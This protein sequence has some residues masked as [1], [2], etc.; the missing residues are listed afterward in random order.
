[1]T[2]S[3]NQ[4]A[5]RFSKANL[6]EHHECAFTTQ[7]YHDPEDMGPFA[8]IVVAQELRF[9]WET[10][11]ECKRIQ[12]QLHRI[13]WQRHMMDPQVKSLFLASPSSHERHPTPVTQEKAIN[14]CCVCCHI[15]IR[16]CQPTCSSPD[17]SVTRRFMCPLP[18]A[19]GS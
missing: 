17:K 19:A 8:C 15:L 2:A 7:Q 4:M 13:Y 11:E 1:M 6:Q 10:C 9:I 12:R 5:P 18:L 16:A 14:A 3:P